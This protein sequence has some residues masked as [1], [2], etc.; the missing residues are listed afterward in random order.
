[1]RE[2]SDGAAKIAHGGVEATLR[3]AQLPQD[4]LDL[5]EYLNNIEYSLIVQALSQ[6]DGVVAHAARLLR[7][8]RTTLVEK[9]RK[10]GMRADRDHR[11]I[12]EAL[13]DN[14]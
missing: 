7:L 14:E 4:G 10:Y 9:L 1:M 5:K 3:L 11:E 8:R 2:S 6:T 13:A 12:N